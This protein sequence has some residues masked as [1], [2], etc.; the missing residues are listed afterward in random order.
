LR[1]AP[2]YAARTQVKKALITIPV[3]KPGKQTFFR[4]HPD[5][6]Y[7]DVLGLLELQEEKEVYLCGPEL[8]GQYSEIRPYMV[9]TYMT[10]QKVLGLWPVPQAG[11][12]GRI[13]Q[14]HETM[15]EIAT[16]GMTKWVQMVWNESLKAHD[17]FF[18][19][20]DLG[21]PEWPSVSFERLLEIAFK[22]KVIT[23]LHHPVIQ[24]LQGKRL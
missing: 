18:A 7:H 3:K 20:V 23:S 5:P 16:A 21:E 19:E 6:A 14:C 13:M 22:G 11:P 15:M 8:L 12:T 1:V 2:E 17:M 24:L 4:I 10:R 9:F